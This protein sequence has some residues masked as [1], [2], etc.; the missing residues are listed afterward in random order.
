MAAHESPELID[1]FTVYTAARTASADASATPSPTG[2][3]A[4]R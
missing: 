3:V 1:L 4:T 2:A